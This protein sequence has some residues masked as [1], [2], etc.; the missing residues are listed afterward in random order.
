VPIAFLN[1]ALLAGLIAVVLPPLIHLLTRRKLDVV[2]WGAMQF[3]DLGKKAR[4]R[5]IWDELLLMALRMGLIAVLVM[6][7]AAPAEMTGWLAARFSH[8]QRDVVLVLDQSGSMREGLPGGQAQKWATTLIDELRP[9]DRVGV[10]A[11]GQSPTIVAPLSTDLDTARSALHL[12]PVPRGGCDGAGAVA[13]ARQMFAD[14]STAQR[15][16]VII[17]DGQRHGWADDGNAQRWEMQSPLPTDSGVSIVMTNLA[18]D[19]SPDLPRWRLEPLRASRA[20]AIVNRPTPMNTELRRVGVG[21][22]PISKLKIEIDGEARE[23]SDTALSDRPSDVIPIELR[24]AFSAPGSHLATVRI[25]SADQTEIDRQDL[26]LDVIMK[27]P[28]L[29]VD[30]DERSNVP[31]GVEFLREALA[32][33]RDPTPSMAVRVIP[34]REFRP[35]LLARPSRVGDVGAG[36]DSRPRVVVLADVPRLTAAQS[37]AIGEFIESG[38]GVL[39]A[40][41]DRADAGHYTADLHRNGKSWFPVSV[42]EQ[43]GLGD[44]GLAPHPL[45]TGFFHPA[46]ELFRKPGPGTLSDARIPRWR[47]LKLPPEGPAAAIARLDGDDPLL[48]EGPFGAGRV[49]V[50][51]IPLDDSERT[52]LVEPPAYVPLIHEL[53]GYL[54][55]ARESECNLAPGQP[56]RWQLPE[57]VPANGWKLISPGGQAQPISAAN[58]RIVIEDTHTP[59]AYR[60]IHD[61]APPRYFV[62]ASDAR[63]TDLNPL[64]DVDRDRLS[65]WLPGLRWVSLPSEALVAATP[66]RSPTDLSWLVFLGVLMLL[67]GELWL[68][69]RRS[70]QASAAA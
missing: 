44:P 20:L 17:S 55:A 68:T 51:A 39:V 14:K 42:G 43:K 19:R 61:A 33:R 36:A 53:I 21:E 62:V 64:G 13:L 41:G 32:P 40:L 58:G 57:F 56:Y 11:A 30:G 45:T 1:A 29:L 9:G 28:V 50:A 63:E 25:L 24:P 70:A 15:L 67:C 8:I 60:L 5:M 65:N 66:A 12:V 22:L 49:I 10:V 59:G 26:A 18:P 52:N 46:L 37:D 31:H 69:R 23:S 54:G 4:R 48:V 47:Q 34:Y 16:V 3:L 2:P 7:L 6:A 35:A 38:G 27:L